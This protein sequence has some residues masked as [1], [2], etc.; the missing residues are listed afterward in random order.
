[1]TGGIGLINRAGLDLIKRY[2]GLEL[3]AYQD[4]VQIWTI[5]YGHT[6]GVKPGDTISEAQ[7]EVFLYED[8]DGAERAVSSNLSAEVFSTIS[9]NHY[10]ALVSF[11]YNV[12]AGSLRRSTLLKKINAGDFEA[13]ANEFKR[14]NKAGGKVLNGLIAR[15]AAEEELFRRE[16]RPLKDSRTIKAA[17]AATASTAAIG[18]ATEVLQQLQPGLT[19]AQR[20]YEWAPILS[21]AVLVIG[22]GVMVWARIDDNKEARR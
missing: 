22:I 20:L 15:R 18:V 13:A 1:M 19:L 11:T 17:S 8:L 16:V 9:A 7:A 12:G 6:R 21:I 10:S 5:G 14:W 2:E 4:P 3:E